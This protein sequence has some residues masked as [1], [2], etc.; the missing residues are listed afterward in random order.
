MK[1]CPKAAVKKHKYH[2][3]CPQYLDH[4]WCIVS[5]VF[6]PSKPFK[7]RKNKIKVLLEKKTSD[8]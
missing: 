5:E 2:V 4:R 6:I 7:T 1:C 3:K 8:T